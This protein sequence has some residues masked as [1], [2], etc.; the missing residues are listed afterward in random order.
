MRDSSSRHLQ[1]CNISIAVSIMVSNPLKDL[2]HKY[3]DDQIYARV[4]KTNKTGHK[5]PTFINLRRSSQS[6]EQV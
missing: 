3:P 6:V 2:K 5:V 4:W 1:F